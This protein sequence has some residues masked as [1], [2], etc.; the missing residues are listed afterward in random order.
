MSDRKLQAQDLRERFAQLGGVSSMVQQVDPADT[1]AGVLIPVVTHEAGL[2]VLLTRR[3]DHLWNH[4]G[5]ISF[6]GGR[7]EP[8]D[9]DAVAAALRET[10]EEVG[11][12][13]AQVEVLGR[14]PDFVTGTGFH[15][16]PVVGL[17]AP[18]LQLKPD[19]FEVAEIF[20]VPLDFLLD[21][22]RYQHHRF[23]RAGQVFQVRA[24]PWPGQFI[25]GATAGMLASLARCMAD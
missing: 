16:V 20:E 10:D 1:S 17:V 5:Q 8:G 23:E 4:A 19:P 14:L 21:L 22:G 11:I 15:V 24:V 3:T 6:P 7:V 25:W 2:T 13:P 12:A 18:P 9:A